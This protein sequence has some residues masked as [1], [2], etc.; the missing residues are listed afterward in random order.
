MLFVLV[1]ALAVWMFFCAYAGYNERFVL[2]LGIVLVGLGVNT[3]WM[4][5]G[6]SA[7]PFSNPAITAHAGIILYGISAGML[8]FLIG[9][10]SR[11]FRASKVEKH[12]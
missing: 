10:I 2:F 9:R 12:D 7:Q 4:M 6:L 3:L 8:G 11:A 1:P 5:I